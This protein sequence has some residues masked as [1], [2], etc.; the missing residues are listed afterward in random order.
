MA[1]GA[2]LRTIRGLEELEAAV[3]S[4]LGVSDWQDI[5]QVDVDAFAAA[6]GD[7]YWLHTDPDRA[8]ASPLGGTVAHGLFTLSLG[9][10]FTYSIVAFEGFSV[11]FNLGYD[12]VR[13]PSPLPTG[14]RVR[15]RLALAGADRGQDGVRVTLLQTFER[16]GEE[17]PA[18]VAQFL[19]HLMT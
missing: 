1:S 8:A 18:C 12:R 7:R 16:E 11:M 15:M 5:G 14:S 2:V 17:R 19:L 3:G 6:T 9:P 4:E 10:A 13:F